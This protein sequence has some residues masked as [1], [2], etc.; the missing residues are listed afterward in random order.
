VQKVLL[1]NASYE[2]LN[3]CSWKRAVVL[4]LKGKAIEVERNGKQLTPDMPLPLVIRLQ[5]YI[6]IPHK[7]IPLTRKNLMHRDKYMCQYCGKTGGDLTVDHILPRSRGGKDEWENVVVA[8]LRCNVGKG[9]RTPEEAGLSIRTKPVRPVNF[10]YFEL[11][12]QWSYAKEYNV[13]E[14]YLYGT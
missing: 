5:H 6:K 10:A 4:L 7:S 13:W 12:K 8:C 9:S 2:P 3:I 14:K 1:L 11:S